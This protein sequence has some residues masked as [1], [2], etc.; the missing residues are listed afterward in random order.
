MIARAVINKLRFLFIIVLIF[1]LLCQSVTP[2]LAGT[3]ANQVSTGNSANNSPKYLTSLRMNLA[4]MLYAGTN[5][6]FVLDRDELTVR[7][8]GKLGFRLYSD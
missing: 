2:V 1:C 6:E 5:R 4:V 8:A 7:V 3:N